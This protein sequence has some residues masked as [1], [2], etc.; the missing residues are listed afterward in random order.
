MAEGR[1]KCANTGLAVLGKRKQLTWLKTRFPSDT[2]QNPKFDVR[3]AAVIYS[4]LSNRLIRAVEQ[5]GTWAIGIP[6]SACNVHFFALAGSSGKI[7]AVVGQ[8]NEG[9]LSVGA[10]R[11]AMVP[12]VSGLKDKSCKRKHELEWHRAVSLFGSAK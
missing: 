5:I 4:V 10:H 2:E 9:I 1:E 8:P 3:T 12:D 6:Q 11:A 7:L